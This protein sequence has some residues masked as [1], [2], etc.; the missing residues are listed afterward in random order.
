MLPVAAPPDAAWIFQALGGP[1]KKHA[2]LLESALAGGHLGRYSWAGV[3]PFLVIAAKDNR[4]RITSAAGTE[5]LIA[6]P[7]AVLGHYLERHRLPPGDY[8]L[9]FWGGAVGYFA[10]D[11]GRRLEVIPQSA[12]DDLGLPDLLLGFY[13][14]VAAVDHLAGKVYA[15]AAPLPEETATSLRRRAAGLAS[16]LEKQAAG[17]PGTAGYQSSVNT[18]SRMGEL[19]LAGVRSHFTRESYCRAVERARD[20]IAA[21]DIFQVNLSQRLSAPLKGDAW[22][23]HLLLRRLNPAPFASFLKFPRFQVVGASPERFLQLSGS[24]VVTRPIK[25][26]R[27]R[28]RDESTDR[29]MREEL[30]NSAKDRAELTMIIDLERNDL[31]RVCKTGSV[32][33]PELFRLEEYPTVFHLVST[34]EGML[35]PGKNVVDLLRATFPGGSITGAPK[36]RAMEII[37]ELEPV[38]RGIY[39]GSTGWIGFHGDADL[40]IVIR[41]V[42]AVDGTAHFHA[43]GGLTADSVPE[44]EYEETLDKARALIRALGALENEVA[45]PGNFQAEGLQYAR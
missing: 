43:G 16:L 7:L 14:E 21:G 25:G 4:V 5:T 38:R 24:R 30:W 36:I 44:A 32:R 35:A 26:T 13:R 11:L 2:F 41:T 10:Y 37:E 33:V 15:C 45:N 22:R 28:G 31:G 20:Y 19:S 6:D 27:P 3:D 39:T 40:N 12:L 23:L 42:V 8:P 29:A 17:A 18:M 9:P 1:A 34:V